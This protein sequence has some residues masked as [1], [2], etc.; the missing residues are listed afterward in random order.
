[1]QW[2]AAPSTSS[3]KVNN[4]NPSRKVA[5]LHMTAA[6]SNNAFT[7]ILGVQG[8]SSLSVLLIPDAAQSSATPACVIHLYGHLGPPE[9]AAVGSAGVTTVNGLPQISGDDGG[10]GVQDDSGLNYAVN[11]RELIGFCAPALVC[12]LTTKPAG[13]EVAWLCVMGQF[14]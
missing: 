7:K 10:D 1:M 8:A 3:P 6:D 9:D 14:N 11:R 2:Y 4:I 13:A 12:Q 5:Y